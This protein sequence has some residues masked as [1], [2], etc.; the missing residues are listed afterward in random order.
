MIN[1][2]KKNIFHG[3]FMFKNIRHLTGLFYREKITK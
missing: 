2:Y 1:K 3:M